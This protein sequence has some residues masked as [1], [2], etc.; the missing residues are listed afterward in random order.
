L[1]FQGIAAARIGR[2]AGGAL[3]KPGMGRH[4]RNTVERLLGLA[5]IR[6]G[7]G[8]PWDVH[9][10]REEFFRRVLAHGTLGLG[11]S[12]M[13]GWWDCPSLD[14]LVARAWSARLPE[15]VRV[16]RDLPRILSARLANVQRGRRAFKIGTHHYDIGDDLYARMLGPT[17]MY[18]CGYWR[19]ADT[20]DAAQTAKLDLIC[21]KLG[22][23]P[24]QRVLDIGC[25]WGTAA[26]YAAEKYGVEVVGVTVSRRQA[27][28]ARKINRGLPVEIRMADYRT[29]DERFDRILSIGMFEHVGYRN[30]RTYFEVVRR[31]LAADG[32]FLLHTIGSP[33]S[34]T[35]TDPWISRYIFPNSNLPSA[36]Q[37][38]RAAEGRMILEDWHNFG[39]DY[40]RTLM[41]W[42]ANIEGA[43]AD[44]DGARYDERFQRMWR[45]YLLS[46]AGSFR[47]RELQLWQLVFA[48]NGVPGG[49]RPGNIR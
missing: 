18:S 32:L 29:L 45:Y 40:D 31:C 44:L 22:L 43:W 25:G 12:W 48:R 39:A 33:R 20:L 46:C 11:E 16:W 37:I 28:Y 13:D 41:S 9:V 26:R 34:K 47:A 6:I 23:E 27:D 42:F 10:Q 7:G 3:L 36:Q 8:R 17:M 19:E 4:Y 49:Y 5:D 21:R 15:R 30:Y 14:Q 35:R 2:P 38:T 1:G 24:G